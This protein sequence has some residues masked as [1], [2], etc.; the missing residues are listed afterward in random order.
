MID[1]WSVGL[2]MMAG[3]QRI[4]RP[5]LSH[6]LGLLRPW[7]EGWELVYLAGLR[8]RLRTMITYQFRKKYELYY[9]IVLFID[10]LDIENIFDQKLKT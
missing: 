9:L 10:K 8:R 5:H 7:E 1:A 3:N 4:C 6:F 2:G